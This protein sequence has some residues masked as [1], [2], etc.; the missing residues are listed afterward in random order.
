M[1][2]DWIKMRSDLHTHP[3]V[4]R[5]ASALNADRLRVVGALHATWCLFDAHSVD[6]SLDGYNNKTLDDMIAFPGFSQA[7]I[8]VGWLEEC[9]SSLC[10]PRFFEHNGQGAKRRAQEAERKRNIRKTSALDAD[11]NRTREE[12]RREE[13][14]DKTPLSGGGEN[15][16]RIFQE[17]NTGPPER[18]VQPE[19]V[20]PA[21]LDG[22]DAPIG[23]F[24]MYDGWM[25]S[26][27]FQRRAA[28]WG[29]VIAGAEPGHTPQE[30]AAFTAY[31]VAEGRALNHIQW[32]QKFADS[33]LYERRQSTVKKP[34]GGS[35]ARTQ[36]PAAGHSGESRAMQKFR[37][38]QAQ[39]C[40]VGGDDRDLCGPLGSQ[41]RGGSTISLDS[42]DWTSD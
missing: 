2:G 24:T 11:K 39:R 7:M 14:K 23:K 25:P 22:V 1:A 16:S 42:G 33:V 37:E 18:P 27:D 15:S 30:L 28:L 5:I 26:A 6:G 4:V 41:E 32:E 21:H 9:E 38:A 3:K 10:M 29:R 20:P 13:V 19:F 36:Q 31:W 34:I 40:G 12:K 8:A 17:E 35:D